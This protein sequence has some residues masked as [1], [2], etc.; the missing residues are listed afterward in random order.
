MSTIQS[1]EPPDTRKTLT[2]I[3]DS[4]ALLCNAHY[5]LNMKRQELSKSELNPSYT[6]LCKKDI[7]PSIKFFG[8]DPSKH[9]KD[10]AEVKMAFI[11]M[12]KSA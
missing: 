1:G 10:M 5:K 2:V 12:Q 11:Q 9:R 3:M 7:K 6:R 8:D 4:I